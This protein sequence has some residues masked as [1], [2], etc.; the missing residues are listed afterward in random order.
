[1]AADEE[2]VARKFEELVTNSSELQTFF[3]TDLNKL[4][5]DAEKAAKDAQEKD[6]T[7]AGG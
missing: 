1:M 7:S 2:E 5:E 3:K 6:G 4:W